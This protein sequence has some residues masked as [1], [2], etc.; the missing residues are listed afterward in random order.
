MR[1]GPSRS[2]GAVR[3]GAAAGNRRAGPGRAGSAGSTAAGRLNGGGRRSAAS[4][5]RCGVCVCARARACVCACGCVRACVCAC[6]CV[7]ACVRVRVLKSVAERR[8]TKPRAPA[9]PPMVYGLS[10]ALSV[11]TA[12][13]QHQTGLKIYPS[14]Y[15]S[16]YLYGLSRSWS[17]SRSQHQ[18]DH[19]PQ[20]ART[21][22]NKP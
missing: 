9:R 4:N 22:Q 13:S 10:R 7:R 5:T 19:A 18:T 16:I 20:A 15:P 17:V 21:K 12:Y 11:L 8:T 1:A 6:A 14:I 2:R 3:S